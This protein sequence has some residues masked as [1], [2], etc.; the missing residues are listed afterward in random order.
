M[1]L[2]DQLQG[3]YKTHGQL[4]PRI[5]VDEARDKKH[6][7]HE[8]FEW[9]DAVAGEKYRE[10]QAAE[11]IRSVRIK[12]AAPGSDDERDVRA[13]HAVT[14]PEGST[15]VPVEEL[16]ADN[17]SR[18]LLLR[19]AER[20]WKAMRRRYAHLEEFFAIVRDDIGH[21]PAA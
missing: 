6:P 18:E 19:Q 3:I 1:S 13:F 4:T 11:L 16:H 8:R 21:E 15:Y 12:F 7:L 9:D 5:V 10:V 17:F 20:E 2:R 14:K